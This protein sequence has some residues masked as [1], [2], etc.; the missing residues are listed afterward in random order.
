M[1]D[2]LIYLPY[3]HP[4]N[5]VSLKLESLVVELSARE[6]IDTANS[7]ISLARIEP[8]KSKINSRKD[9]LKTTKEKLP[10]LTK[11]PNKP[12]DEDNIGGFIFIANTERF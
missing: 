4:L 1:V 3:R 2:S 9:F 10:L 12:G 5:E 7:L 11:L 8:L 6:L